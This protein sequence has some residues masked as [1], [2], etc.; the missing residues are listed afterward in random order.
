MGHVLFGVKH[1]GGEYDD[2]HGEREDEEAQFAGAGGQR[3]AEDA[4]A[5]RVTRELEDAKHAEDAQRDEGAADLVVVGDAEP[6]VVRQDRHD[7]DHRHH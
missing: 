1:D 3:A 2:G 6:D 4:K 7:V 5:G